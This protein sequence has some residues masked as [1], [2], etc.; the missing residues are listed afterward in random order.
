MWIAA[1]FMAFQETRVAIFRRYKWL[2]QTRVC[3]C[4]LDYASISVYVCYIEEYLYINASVH[5]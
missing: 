5:V 1:E 3:V 2:V 4:L